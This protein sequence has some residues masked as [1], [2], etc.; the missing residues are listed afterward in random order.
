MSSQGTS[1]RPTEAV[2]AAGDAVS[3]ASP[4]PPVPPVPPVEAVEAVLAAVRELAATDW[5][6]VDRHGLVST[7]VGIETVRSV[8]DAA[9]V[10]LVG[11]IETTRAGEVEGWA[12]TAQLV[13][14]VSGGAKGAG[15]GLV[16]L[17]QRLADLPATRAAM[18]AGELSRA[19]ASVIAGKVSS[20]PFDQELRTEAE[21]VLLEAARTLDAADLD[22]SWPR[23]IERLDPDGTRL[24]DDFSVERRE[25]AANQQRHL[26]L[27]PDRHGG[28]KWTG[29]SSA[30]DAE[31][32]KATL[33]PLTAPQP[34]E[35]GS[36]GG[37]PPDP[38]APPPTLAEWRARRGP[39]ADG[40][41]AHDGRDPREHG[42][43]LLD[44]L[45][46]VCRQ[47]QAR[48]G[49]PGED[50]LPADHGAVPRMLV[51]TTLDA[52]RAGLAHEQ[53]GMPLWQTN[54]PSQPAE[55]ADAGQGCPGAGDGTTD[56]AGAGIRV[57]GLV[58][59]LPLSVAAV[60]RLACD[61]EIIPAV[62]G[63]KGQVLDLGRS[64]R[65]VSTAQWHALMLRDGGCSFPGCGRLPI[66]CDAHHL[67]HWVDGGRTDLA[68]L[69]VLC[70]RHHTVLHT[71]PWQAR[72]NP[73]DGKPEFRPPPRRDHPDPGWIRHRQPRDLLAG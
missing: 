38:A 40:G 3:P 22:R 39:C 71:S 45:V 66:A 4:V 67:V 19:K 63:S 61:A 8:L 69:V 16:R 27:T 43:R 30:E 46:T 42:A 25:R 2:A 28:V 7:L 18:A 5:L 55:S 32:V 44:A 31:L 6:S 41:C 12:S 29:Y 58:N 47:A 70:R 64:Q 21:Q 26:A 23:V 24:G 20:L 50:G 37:T 52:I 62:L 60:R 51:S 34:A 57:G 13:T 59:G 65:L 14:A 53:A 56:P 73:G 36:C 49:E 10:D 54:Q 9:T 72:I 1:D 35:P 33:L 11:R 68:N 15:P 48:A 17:A